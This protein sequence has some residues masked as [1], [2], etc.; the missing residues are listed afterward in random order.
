LLKH[1]LVSPLVPI[2]WAEESA[3]VL[4]AAKV[5]EERPGVITH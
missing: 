5:E 4:P 2:E 1:A 3:P